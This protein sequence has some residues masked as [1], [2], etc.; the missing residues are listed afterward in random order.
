M[1]WLIERICLIGKIPLCNGIASRAPHLF[2]Y[3][4][5]LCYRCTFFVLF[6]IGTLYFIRKVEVKSIRYIWLL[7]VPMIIDGCAQTF[8]G[9]MSTNFRRSITGALF[10]LAAAFLLKFIFQKIDRM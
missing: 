10:G 2:G 4:F 3:C 5:I 9:Y 6:F 7:L 1:T 8:F